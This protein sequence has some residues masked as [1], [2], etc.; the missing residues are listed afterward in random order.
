MQVLQYPDLDGPDIRQ[1]QEHS[2]SLDQQPLAS[3]SMGQQHSI[4]QVAPPYFK[5]M[6]NS[7]ELLLTDISSQHQSGTSL[8]TPQACHPG[9]AQ[10][11]H[12]LHKHH[13]SPQSACPNLAAP[14]LERCR[15]H[16]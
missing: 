5:R 12:Q 16:A 8:Q 6:H 2:R 11:P 9:A 3:C 4:D 14:A 10:P 1:H 15:E 7:K 13:R